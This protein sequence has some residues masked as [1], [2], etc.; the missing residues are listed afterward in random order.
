MRTAKPA[1]GVSHMNVRR[2]VLVVSAVIA[3]TIV[4][5]TLDVPL[6]AAAT[7]SAVVIVDGV[8]I[9]AISGLL[10][11]QGVVDEANGICH[12]VDHRIEIFVPRT[13]VYSDVS[14]GVD[15]DCRLRVLEVIFETEHR[16]PDGTV[17]RANLN[18]GPTL[19]GRV[20]PGSIAYAD[21]QHEMYGR[22]LMHEQAH[23]T[24]SLAHRQFS[25]W[26]G[27]TSV[28]SPAT[29]GAYCWVDGAGWNILAC[30]GWNELT[31]PS[32]VQEYTYGDFENQGGS[33]RHHLGA[34]PQAWIGGYS[35]FC[36]GVGSSMPFGW[37]D[38]CNEVA[39]FY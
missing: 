34:H 10:L 29:T 25:Y 2:C 31:G 9:T 20:A 5:V 36:D 15:R 13:I 19:R 7:P 18:T 21:T 32:Q 33:L 30:N 27:P 1:V 23:I 24:V 37:H 38:H 11:K 12:E 17:I 6:A 16:M 8:R 22:H 3:I 4:P 39:R 14:V 26:E 28:Y 35:M